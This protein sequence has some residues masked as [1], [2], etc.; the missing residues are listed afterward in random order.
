MLTFDFLRFKSEDVH[1]TGS[2][3][4]EFCQKLTDILL[5]KPVEH[6][7]LLVMDLRKALH[8][9]E[10]EGIRNVLSATCSSL[11]LLTEG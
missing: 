3:V 5:G 4:K 11:G 1:T 9:A 7:P 6:D 2:V 10:T 8:L